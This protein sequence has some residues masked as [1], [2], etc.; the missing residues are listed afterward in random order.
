MNVLLKGVVGSTAYGLAHEGSDIDYL[1]VFVA[2]NEELLGLSKTQ[3]SVVTKD[4]DTAMHEAR[5]F[6]ALCLNGNPSVSEL[7]WLDSYEHMTEAGSDLLDLR[8]S[9]LSARQ[10]RDSYIG[11]AESQF[12]RLLRRGD[13]SFSADTRNRTPK[14]ARHMVR[15]VEQGL[16]LYV[17]GDLVVDLGSDAS[18]IDP[19]WVVGMGE[20][21]TENSLWAERYMERA[22][23]RFDQ[24]KTVL[25]DRPDREA[26]EKWLIGVRRANWGVAQ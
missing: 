17:T 25:P 8:R 9:F 15:L 5:K 14:H 22:R 26:V 7:L 19:D 20:R 11:Y 18:D 24:A 23:E 21:I 1:G 2:P 4:P 16:H 6:A 13:G 10:V 3:E 12:G